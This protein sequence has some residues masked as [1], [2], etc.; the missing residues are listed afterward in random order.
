MNRQKE[1]NKIIES[2]Y[3][4]IKAFKNED[5]NIKKIFGGL[6]SKSKSKSSKIKK[7]KL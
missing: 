6:K 4:D 1:I 7:N 3:V 2:I 5:K